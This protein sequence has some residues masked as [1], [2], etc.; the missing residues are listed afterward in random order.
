MKILKYIGIGILLILAITIGPGLAMVFGTCA[1]LGFIVIAGL[2]AI[3]VIKIP[4]GDNIN[5][6]LGISFVVG[7]IL[8]II[9]FGITGLPE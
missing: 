9:Y 2:D 6:L 5:T 8:F 1:F 4:A 7:L 3:G